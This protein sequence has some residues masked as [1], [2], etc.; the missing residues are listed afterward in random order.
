MGSMRNSQMNKTKEKIVIIKN[1]L[2][3]VNIKFKSWQTLFC[4]IRSLKPPKKTIDMNRYESF[5]EYE[6]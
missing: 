4:G 2:C 5:L 1:K 3:I 6:L